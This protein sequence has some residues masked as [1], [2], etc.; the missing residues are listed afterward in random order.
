MAIVRKTIGIE[1]T[2]EERAAIRA[3]LEAARKLPF[4]YDP[5][6]PPLTEEELAEFRPANGMTWAERARHM[7]ERGIVDPEAQES[8]AEEEMIHIPAMV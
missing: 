1:V 5:E 6:C 8:V 3:E 7:Q 2:P 4:V